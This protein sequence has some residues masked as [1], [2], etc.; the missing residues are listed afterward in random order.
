[1]KKCGWEDW[2]NVEVPPHS[3]KY[4]CQNDAVNKYNFESF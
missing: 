2:T 3:P 4:V 1:M